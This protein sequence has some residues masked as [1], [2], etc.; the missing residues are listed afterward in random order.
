MMLATFSDSS[1][2]ELGLY[3][4][5]QTVF[6]IPLGAMQTCILDVADLSVEGTITTG[7][8][9]AAILISNGVNA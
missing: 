7:G 9:T 8:A 4:K 5:W 6:F 3:Y 1:V 2:T